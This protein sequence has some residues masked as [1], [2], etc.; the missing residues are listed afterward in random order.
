[1]SFATWLELRP[2]LWPL[3]EG[4]KNPEWLCL[5]E[6][7]DVMVPASL[8]VYAVVFKSNNVEDYAQTLNLLW[9]ISSCRRTALPQR[10]P[11]LL[12]S[13]GERNG[14]RCQT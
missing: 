11:G 2:T 9:P 6:L 4:S 12:V 14:T 3:M 1:M 10:S 7:F 13:P 8:L 5:R